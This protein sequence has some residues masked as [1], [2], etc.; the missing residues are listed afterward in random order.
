MSASRRVFLKVSG[1]ALRHALAYAVTLKRRCVI[2]RE[3]SARAASRLGL[4]VRETLGVVRLLSAVNFTPTVERL[5]LIAQRDP[6]LDDEDIGEIFG[7]T[8]EWSAEVRERADELRR[9]EQIPEELE[10][11][12]ED[13]QPGDLS[14]EAIAERAAEVREKRRSG[15]WQRGEPGIRTYRWSSKRASFVCKRP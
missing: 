6:G 13:L 3:P 1:G 11:L 15:Y 5:A 14:P 10:W 9:R 4:D 12:T 8:A 7:R 2:N